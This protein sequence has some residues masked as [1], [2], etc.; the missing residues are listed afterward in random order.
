[1]T[2]DLHR[3]YWIYILATTILIIP[4]S[5][6]QRQ[7]FRRFA[8]LL[9]SFSVLELWILWIKWKCHSSN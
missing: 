5:E 1:V 8:R 9:S 2:V 6:E 3:A 4:S 7:N